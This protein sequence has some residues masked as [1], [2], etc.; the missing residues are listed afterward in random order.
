MR[1][2]MFPAGLLL[3]S[4]VPGVTAGVF[5]FLLLVRGV[6]ASASASHHTAGHC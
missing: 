5:R 6:S 3:Q 4:L 1:G 2:R